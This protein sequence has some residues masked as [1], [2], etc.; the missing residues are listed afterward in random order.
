MPPPSPPIYSW[1]KGSN[2][3][4]LSPPI[5]HFSLSL[6]LVSP[7]LSLLF[8]E[9]FSP[10]PAYH[11]L[12]TGGP[13]N[14]HCLKPRFVGCY[15]CGPMFECCQVPSRYDTRQMCRHLHLAVSLIFFLLRAIRTLS[16]RLPDREHSA[17]SSLPSLWL[18]CEVCRGWHSANKAIPVVI[19]AMHVH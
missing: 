19:V 18:P 3:D 9:V 1:P 7:S 8:G 15:L 4:S 10:T 6:A 2:G 12:H 5:E 13:S 17:N 14:T 16:C 11:P